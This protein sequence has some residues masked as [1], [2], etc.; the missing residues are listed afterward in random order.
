MI[1]LLQEAEMPLPKDS[2]K[3]IEMEGREGWL[4]HQASFV[5]RMGL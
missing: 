4:T 5:E 1:D 3:N 2:I